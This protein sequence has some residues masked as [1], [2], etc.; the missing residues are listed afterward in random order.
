MRAA[1]TAAMTDVLASAGSVDATAPHS[2]A[3]DGSSAQPQALPAV[4]RV[5]Q[6]GSFTF[7]EVAALFILLLAITAIPVVL[8][9]WPPI[10]DYINHLAR[11]HV[12]ATIQ[13]DPDLA[14]F[15]EIDWQLIPNLMMDLI[16]PWLMRVVNVYAA[17]QI[18]TTAS[19][20]LILSGTF[21]LHRHLYAP[22]SPL[23]LLP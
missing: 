6:P 7:G 19:F 11:M 4:V 14:R 21:A 5:R 15:Y 22:W 13:S 9:P 1:M 10:S 12:I 23:P 2:R 17:G 18:Y 20:V 8:H 3:G 16:V